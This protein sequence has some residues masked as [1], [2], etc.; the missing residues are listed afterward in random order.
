MGAAFGY[1]G[2]S[3]DAANRE[4]RRC[5]EEITRQNEELHRRRQEAEEASGRKT[6]L[7]ASVSHDMRSPLHAI[8]LTAEV[9]RCTAADPALAAKVPG[10]ARRLQANAAALGDL[11]SDLLDISSLE[12]GRVERH[13]GELS[14]NELLAEESRRWLPLAQAKLAR[15][16]GN[17][18]TVAIKFTEAGGVTLSAGLTPEEAVDIRV[19]DTRVGIPAESLGRIFDEFAQL[20]NPGRDP[21]KGWGLGL[22]ICRRLV[23]LMGG[24]VSVESQLDQGS[25]FSARLPPSCVLIGSEAGPDGVDGVPIGP[26]GRTSVLSRGVL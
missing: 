16:L 1:P 15:V 4:L 14:L 20:R 19:H 6:R 5:H 7:L 13:D 12:S 17:L 3:L 2:A 22:A 23:E 10:L 11:V 25:V 8:N 24:A 21:T 26:A 18:V 9:I